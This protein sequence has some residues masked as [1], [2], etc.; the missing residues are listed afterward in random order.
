[1]SELFIHFQ[2]QVT[3]PRARLSPVAPI[4]LCVNSCDWISVLRS[5][6]HDIRRKSTVVRG[7]HTGDSIRQVV[8]RQNYEYLQFLDMQYLK[9]ETIIEKKSTVVTQWSLSV[10]E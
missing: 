1:M 4:V 10:S 6:L 3:Q 9:Q 2:T 5:R 7:L 8:Y